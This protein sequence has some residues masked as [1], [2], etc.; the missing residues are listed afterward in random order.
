[1]DSMFDRLYEKK[2]WISILIFLISIIIIF[3]TKDSGVWAGIR[4]LVALC[5]LSFAFRPYLCLRSLKAAYGGFAL[6]LGLGLAIS[7]LAAWVPSALSILGFNTFTCY[8]AVL[9][10]ALIGHILSLTGRTFFRWNKDEAADF[11]TGIALFSLLFAIGFYI[12]GIDGNIYSQTEQFMDFGFM[13]TIYRQEVLPPEDMWFS[14]ESLNYY[15]L[16]QAAAVFLCRLSFVTPEYGYGLMF[17]TVFAGVFMM[18]M[19]IIQALLYTF[20]GIGRK[21]AFTGGLF[22]AIATA[23]GSN[24]H[25]IIYG[26]LLP[27]LE[28]LT[29]AELA[30]DFW[31]PDSTTFIGT[32]AGNDFGKHEF[33]AYSVVLGDLHAH[34]CNMLFTLPLLAILMDLVLNDLKDIKDPTDGGEEEERRYQGFTHLLLIGILLGLY[35]GT[36]YWDFP[37]YLTITV[38]MITVFEIKGRGMS[39]AA[40]QNAVLK[41]GSVFFAGFLIMRP[42]EMKLNNVTEGVHLCDR[43]SDPMEY[44]TVWGP[45]IL[46]SLVLFG[47]LIRE[48]ASGK[49]KFREWPSSHLLV[50]V[51]IICA[52]GLIMMPEVVYVKDIYGENYQRFNTMFK[53]TYQ[54]FILFGIITGVSIPLFLRKKRLGRCYGIILVIFCLISGTYLVKSADMWLGSLVDINSRKGLSAYGNFMSDTGDYR[55]EQEIFEYLNSDGRKHINVLEGSGTSYSTDCKMSVFTGSNTVVGWNTHEWLWHGDWDVVS[56][57]NAEVQSFYE[58]G[59]MDLCRQFLGRYDIDYVYIGPSEMSKYAIDMSGF[60]PLAD[61]MMTDSCGNILLVYD[62]G[63]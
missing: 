6:S 41:S 5:T 33:P 8:A 63:E 56:R 36:N 43:H 52:L 51:L 46:I 12:R 10:P 28:R 20:E 59:D 35:K 44:L 7:F 2:K 1:M 34:V 16:G 49:K 39:L 42:F 11:I 25:Y 37:I 54:A 27:F 26:L 29:G 23:C 45:F 3:S 30:K 60:A 17:V 50:M 19:T 40:L 18:I 21:E 55:S 58:S 38:M 62:S 47:L 9:I 53:L 22:G 4:W 14:G 15:Y 48:M 24:G 57:R 31:F 13:R 32:K 61:D